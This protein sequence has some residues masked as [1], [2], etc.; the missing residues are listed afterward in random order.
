M[1]NIRKGRLAIAGAVLGLFAVVAMGAS[2]CDP[3]T[4]TTSA[5]CAFIVGDG[6]SGHNA[7]VHRILWQ[8]EQAEVGSHEDV[9]YVP[10][11]SRNYL[12]KPTGAKN[13]NGQNVGDRSA[14]SIAYTDTGTKV[15]VW[16]SS[17]WTLNQ[18]K[19]AMAKF[20]EVCLKYNCA[21]DSPRAGTANFSTPGWNGMLG[22]NFGPAVDDAAFAE[23]A[24]FNDELWKSHK[25]ALYKKLGEDMSAAFMESVRTKTGYNADLFCGSGNSVWTGSPG[26][27]DFTCRNVRIVINDVEPFNTDLSKQVDKATQAQQ[28]QTV[29]QKKFKAAKEL[30]G[31]EAG[32]WLGVQDSIEKC[33]TS[34]VTCVINIGG[35]ST[36]VSV[37]ARG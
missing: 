31:A 4:A 11:N 8:N 32:Y 20:W 28:D 37:P 10:C 27:S 33:R 26:H 12:I 19:Q 9:H 6:H 7:T 18:D 16:S 13:A 17:Y 25:P 35:G 15:R 34:S 3:N 36:N 21:S 22:E 24:R 30:Y 5:S 14:S 1:K 23:V 2:G 29:N